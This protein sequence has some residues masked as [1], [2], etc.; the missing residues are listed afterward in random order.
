MRGT[1]RGRRPLHG[2][3]SGTA[4]VLIRGQA[5][6]VTVRWWTLLAGWVGDGAVVG[7]VGVVGGRGF[8]QG[9]EDSAV[10]ACGAGGAAADDADPQRPGG[11]GIDRLTDQPLSISHGRA[12]SAGGSKPEHWPGQRPI[13]LTSQGT[14]SSPAS[15]ACGIALHR[16]PRAERLLRRHDQFSF[17]DGSALGAG[18]PAAGPPGRLATRRLRD[19]SLVS[20]R[21]PRWPRQHHTRAKVSSDSDSQIPPGP[22]RAAPREPAQRT[23]RGDS[24]RIAVCRS[25][26]SVM[27]GSTRRAGPGRAWVV[28][29]AGC[30]MRV[31]HL[32]VDRRDQLQ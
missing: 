3:G 22:R 26:A 21:S 2:L 6:A 12:P 14:Q 7:F 24:S 18:S 11:E 28:A 15:S 30:D 27:P 8:A 31:G 29:G 4:Q 17:P 25:T 9:D 5:T 20:Q 10:L 1:L 32:R 16:T 23:R 19:W 13:R